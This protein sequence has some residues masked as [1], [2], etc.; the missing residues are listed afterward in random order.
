[1][2][3]VLSARAVSIGCIFTADLSGGSVT[4]SGIRKLIVLSR[5]SSTPDPRIGPELLHDTPISELR[6]IYTVS[7]MVGAS[8]RIHTPEQ[9]EST[10]EAH[11]DVNSHFDTRV[12]ESIL[13]WNLINVMMIEEVDGIAYRL[14]VG[15]IHVAAFMEAGPV[16][17]NIMLE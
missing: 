6:S 12:Y 16:A 17:E 1:M 11:L 9:V 7:H 3:R 14:A 13:P 15:R 5:G 2:A 10:S 4:P 8:S